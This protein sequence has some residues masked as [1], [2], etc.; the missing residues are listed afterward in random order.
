[1]LTKINYSLF[2]FYLSAFMVTASGTIQSSDGTSMFLVTQRIIENNTIAFEEGLGGLAMKS[3]RDGN[4]YSKYG[5]G[6]SVFIMPLFI[7]GKIIS[8]LTHIPVEFSTK[9]V[10][11]FYN[12][13]I[14]AATCLMLFLFCVKLG[15]KYI[16]SLI[17]S[18]MYGF[19]TMAWHYSQSFM[20]EPTTALFIL[21]AVYFVTKDKTRS[22]NI[23]GSGLFLSLAIFTRAVSIIIAPCILFYMLISWFSEK[24][25]RVFQDLLRNI[26]LFIF[27]VLIAVIEFLYFNYI[28]FGDILITGHVDEDFSTNLFWGIYGLLFSTGKGLFIY[29]PVIILSISGFYYFYKDRKNE[30]ILFLS[31]ILAHVFLYSKW[32]SWYA[33]M[34]WGGRFLLVVIPY[35][36]IMAKY[37]IESKNNY[38][39]KGFIILTVLGILT[40][41]SSLFVNTSRQYYDLRSKY[42]NDYMNKLLFSP[43]YFP[44]IYQWKSIPIVLENAL[45]E[46][47]VTR[48]INYA[49][50]R[51]KFKFGEE[52]QIME[53]ALAI[54]VPNFWWVYAWLYGIPKWLILSSLTIL[55]TINI[56]TGKILLSYLK[57]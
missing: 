21:C 51:G 27:P 40:Q 57:Y 36:V 54:N 14:T 37:A 12:S 7:I 53:N 38:L 31:I 42:P 22:L 25:K 13:F 34:S 17:I 45:N 35:F 47:Y 48:L 24:D 4:Y 55:I 56:V 44:V 50:K 30:A 41:F 1:M 28:R 52:N 10:A 19:S 49:I 26:T 9:F 29:N 6:Q 32:H 2:V 3:E 39:K 18:A 20:S 8:N 11:S 33:G 43:K 23:L 5:L 46:N 15:Y 16:T